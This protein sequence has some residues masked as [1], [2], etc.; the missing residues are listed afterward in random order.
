LF[1]FVLFECRDP[2]NLR[3]AGTGLAEELSLSSGGSLWSNR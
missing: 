3:Q 2:N 1:L